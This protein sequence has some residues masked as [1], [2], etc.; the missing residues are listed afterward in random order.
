MVKQILL[1]KT[2][3]NKKTGFIF[4]K[5]GFNKKTGFILSAQSKKGRNPV[6]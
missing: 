4:E 3:F 6:F 5:T 2:G 1:E